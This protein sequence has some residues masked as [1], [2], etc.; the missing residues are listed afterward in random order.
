MS[1]APMRS[2]SESIRFVCVAKLVRPAKFEMLN[3]SVC[4]KLVVA[5]TLRQQH[6]FASFQNASGEPA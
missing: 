4:A 5:E 6:H 2:G 1:A 3:G